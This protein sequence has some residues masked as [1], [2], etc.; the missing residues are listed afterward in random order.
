MNDTVEPGL[1]VGYRYEVRDTDGEL[2]AR[3]SEGEV[4]YYLHGHGTSPTGLE[5]HMEGREIGDRFSVILDPEEAYGEDDDDRILSV[6]RSE[7]P[8]DVRLAPGLRVVATTEQ[9]TELPL[10]ILEV[11]DDAVS[12]GVSHPLAGRTLH[13]DVEIVSIRPAGP[14]EVAVGH[15][16]EG[17][18]LN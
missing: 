10:W 6:P 2:I 12:L 17:G 14:E 1:V 4:A 15:P 5:P 3:S 9:G 7:F 13:F 8:P 11:E 16:L 18:M